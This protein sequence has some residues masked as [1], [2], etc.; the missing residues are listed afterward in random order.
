MKLKLLIAFAAALVLIGSSAFAA[1]ADDEAKY[2]QAIEKRTADIM[3]A[4]DVKDE[5]KASRVHDAIMNQYR[6][7]RDWQQKNDAAKKDKDTAAQ[8]QFKSDRKALHD[9]FLAR[10][11]ADLSPEQVETVKDKLTYNKVKVTYDAYVEIIPSLTTEQRAKVMELLKQA[12]EEAMDG[13]SSEEKSAIF[14]KYKGKINNYFVA[15]GIDEKKARKEWDEKRK[16][17]KTPATNPAG[18]D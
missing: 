5:A 18:G 14:K 11:N 13:V 8:E 2:T 3:S 16:A 7:L 1:Q 15:Q 4:L 17:S 6:A 12:R 9:Q 10:L